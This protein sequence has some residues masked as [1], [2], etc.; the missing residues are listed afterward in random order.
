MTSLPLKAPGKHLLQDF[1]LAVLLR[2]RNSTLHRA[3]SLCLCL[4]M[5]MFLYGH[6]SHKV[7]DN[8]TLVTFATA[9]FP[10]KVVLG[11]G[12]RT[13]ICAFFFLEERS[14]VQSEIGGHTFLLSQ[15]D[16]LCQ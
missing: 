16:Q 10:D 1:L 7:R 9:L 2:Q 5:G 14:T 11:A 6:Q 13:L 15:L 3:F 12:T 4:F 8:T